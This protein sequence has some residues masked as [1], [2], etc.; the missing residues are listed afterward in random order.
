[1]SSIQ[2]ADTLPCRKRICANVKGAFSRKPGFA[3]LIR[4]LCT[5]ALLL[6]AFRAEA[7][8]VFTTLAS[9]QVLTNGGY[10]YGGLVQGGDGNLYGTALGGGTN[11]NGTVFEIST[12]GALTCLHLFTGSD[13][14]NPAA[15]LVQGSDGNLYG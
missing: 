5:A 3:L 2:N 14:A 4:L 9:F 13:G 12:N 15:R 11:S 6:P 7:G 10:P 8:V 1:M